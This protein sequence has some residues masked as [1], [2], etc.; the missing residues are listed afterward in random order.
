MQFPS[1]HSQQTQFFR[2]EPQ[3]ARAPNVSPETAPAADDAD[4]ADAAADDTSTGHWNQTPTSH[5]VPSTAHSG[6]P[7]RAPHPGLHVGAR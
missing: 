1:L 3:L 5:P 2:S 6:Q 4:T 7:R